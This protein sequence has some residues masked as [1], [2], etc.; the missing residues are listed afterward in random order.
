MNNLPVH[1]NWKNDT[2]S[3]YLKRPKR[4]DVRET[5]SERNKNKH[6]DRDPE[7][8]R[9]ERERE[10]DS[11]YNEAQ[12][13]RAKNHNPITFDRNQFLSIFFPPIVTS[14]V[15]GASR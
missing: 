11:W 1:K 2:Q 6:R 13:F 4:E 15:Q 10:R 7:W 5:K 14:Q 8:V 9:R 3:N 12:T